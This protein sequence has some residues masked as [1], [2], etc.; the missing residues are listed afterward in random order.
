[1]NKFRPMQL[2]WLEICRSK[3][4]LTSFPVVEG[5]FYDKSYKDTLPTDAFGEN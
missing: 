2:F 1:M 5:D 4:N 3:H